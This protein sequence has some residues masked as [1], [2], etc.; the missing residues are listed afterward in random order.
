M[1]SEARPSVGDQGEEDF[2]NQTWR[3]SC[4]EVSEIPKEREH[5]GVYP[6][7]E[8]NLDGFELIIEDDP[9]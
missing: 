9:P 5:P 2:L 6:E 3:R 8:P 1:L 4:R 7:W